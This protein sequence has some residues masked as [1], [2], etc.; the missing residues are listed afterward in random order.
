MS[1]ELNVP[2]NWGLSLG[3]LHVSS[4]PGDAKNELLTV[5]V[6]DP[7]QSSPFLHSFVPSYFPSISYMWP[8]Q[9][10][11]VTDSFFFFLLASRLR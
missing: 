11:L 1:K 7:S 3:H 8:L 9:V 4:V 2:E 10:A 6:A 5:R